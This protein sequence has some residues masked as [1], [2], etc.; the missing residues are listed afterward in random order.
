MNKIIWTMN[1]IEKIDKLLEYCKWSL[2]I[3][4]NEH[5][6]Y[7]E[8]IEHHLGSDTDEYIKEGIKQRDCLISIQAFL[9]PSYHIHVVHY[10]LDSAL[11]ATLCQIELEIKQGEEEYKKR[12]DPSSFEYQLDQRTREIYQELSRNIK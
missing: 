10:D 7:Y 5:R 4:Y 8:P 12:N 11:D 3:V 6:D 1:T 2:W 9:S